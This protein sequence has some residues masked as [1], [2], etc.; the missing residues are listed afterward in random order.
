MHHPLQGLAPGSF[1][2]PFNTPAYVRQAIALGLRPTF[3][4]P[5][6][7]SALDQYLARLEHQ[8]PIQAQPH[9]LAALAAPPF[10]LSPGGAPILYSTP[11]APAAPEVDMGS[12]HPVR[13]WQSWRLA[14]ALAQRRI[15]ANPLPAPGQPPYRAAYTNPETPLEWLAATPGRPAGWFTPSTEAPTPEDAASDA[16]ER[17]R[18][19]LA[20][21][22]QPTSLTTPLTP[23]E[24]RCR[25]LRSIP[26]TLDP[27]QSFLRATPED[28]AFLVPPPAPRDPANPQALHPA[29]TTHAD[30]LLQAFTT[31]AQEIALGLRMFHPTS[32]HRQWALWSTSGLTRPDLARAAFSTPE[33]LQATELAFAAWQIEQARAYKTPLDQHDFLAKNFGCAPAEMMQLIKAGRDTNHIAHQRTRE[34]KEIEASTQL[35]DV[36]SKTPDDSVRLRA[37]VD[38]AR[39]HGLTEKRA[40]TE[41]DA[42]D[43]IKVMIAIQKQAD[44]ARIETKPTNA[45]KIID[46]LPAQKVNQLTPDQR[47]DR[48]A[49]PVDLE[50]A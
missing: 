31:L 47:K 5:I 42:E 46:V 18:A 45:G 15:Q 26:N 41:G 6:Q 14:R 13:M 3:S 1:E 22:A 9:P 7:L 48:W 50:N 20:G 32:L 43:L 2:L 28:L 33:E 40:V 30:T 4:T 8:T 36:A 17:A 38:L 11:T 29:Y 10:A 39:V 37:I 21:A 24:A 25:L 16:L 23:A 49:K 34:D 44:A 27:S 35:L 12:L 19:H